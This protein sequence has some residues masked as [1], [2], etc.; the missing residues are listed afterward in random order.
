M[1]KRGSHIKTKFIYESNV[2]VNS[3]YDHLPSKTPRY[4]FMGEFPTP[5]QKENL[6]LQPPDLSKQAKT[7][8]LGHFPQLF[9]IKPEKNH[10]KLQDFIIFEAC[11]HDLFSRIQFLLVLN[12]GSC[13][14]TKNDLPSNG[15][16]ILKKRM[17]IQHA[18]FS[19][20]ILLER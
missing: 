15:S 18:L 4:I 12:N 6:K 9:T 13:E 11:S 14:H 5:G 3:K 17:E 8:S 19:F 7:P 2:S 16:L 1:S 20:D 10:A